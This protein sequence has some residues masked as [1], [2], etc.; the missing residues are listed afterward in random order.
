MLRQRNVRK[1]LP[2]AEGTM[3]YFSEGVGG[4]HNVKRL[5]SEPSVALAYKLEKGRKNTLLTSD[6]NNKL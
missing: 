3:S 1:D 6:N 4:Q 5:V 2:S